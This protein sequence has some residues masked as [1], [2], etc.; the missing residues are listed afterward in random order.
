M[1]T[2]AAAAEPTDRTTA[3]EAPCPLPPQ[4]TGTAS[5][6]TIRPGG[7]DD[8]WIVPPR[9]RLSDGTSIQLYKDGEAW[10]AAFD[11]LRDARSRICLEIYI[12]AS[13]DT[14]RAVAEVLCKKARDGVRV[15]VIY[16]S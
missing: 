15:Y 10:H 4:Q 12:F 14:G 16:D 8:G 2:T 5:G 9:V 6:R 1:T 3:L 13:D 7:N 11:A